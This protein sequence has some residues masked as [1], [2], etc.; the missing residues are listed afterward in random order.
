VFGRYSDRG[1]QVI[2]AAQDEAKRL[3]FGYVSTEHLLLALLQDPES[4]AVRALLRLGVSLPALR[5]TLEEFMGHGTIPVV[6]QPQ[7]TPR[8]KRV[9]MELALEAARRLGHA[10]VGTEHLLLGLVDEGECV[11][12]RK[13]G[14]LGINRARLEPEIRILLDGTAPPPVAPPHDPPIPTYVVR[15][16]AVLLDA[17]GRPLVVRR[18]GRSGSWHLPRALVEVHESSHGAAVRAVRMTAG[19]TARCGRL[20]WAVEER[21]GRGRALT[22]YFWVEP[23]AGAAATPGEGWEIAYEPRG[24]ASPQVSLPAG[25]W[26][27]LGG[28]LGGYDPWQGPPDLP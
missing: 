18:R 1:Q 7:Y 8:G 13:L 27:V 9:I 24:S 10:Y 15:G 5:D 23:E 17:K 12:A 2:L 20:L 19:I 21:G 22:L 25:F 28:A 11:A 3:R 6:G 4:V 26:E 14:E 16:G